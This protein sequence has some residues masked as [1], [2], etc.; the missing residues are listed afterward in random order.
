MAT[1]NAIGTQIPIEVAKGGTGATTLTIHGVVIGNAAGVV[2]VTA[3]G[4]AGTILTGAG[5]AADPTWTTATYPATTLQGDLLISAAANVI[6]ALN[7]DAN[8]TRYLSNTGADN[9]PAW[10][11]IDLTN[12]VTG[13][14]PV[15]SGGIGITNPTAHSVILGGGEGAM[16]ALGAATNGQLIVGST[17]AAPVLATLTAGAGIGITNAAGAITVSAIGSGMSWNVVTGA[18]QAVV[19]NGYICNHAGDRVVVTLPD[20]A[21]VGS[22]VELVGMGA[23]GFQLAQNAD[24]TVYIGSTATTAGVGGSLASTD[25][26]DCLELVCIEENLKFRCK[27]IVGNITVV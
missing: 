19:G 12:G 18:T 22:I 25:A 10:A 17:D 5:A 13:T 16:T 15:G 27:T 2:N 21:P 1:M 26:G 24:Q 7:K 20:T 14:L 3:A 9:T 23:A 4:N 6:S 8:A 11:Q